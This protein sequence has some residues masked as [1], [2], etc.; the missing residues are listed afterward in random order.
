MW[1][2]V[3]DIVKISLPPECPIVLN[4]SNVD[5]L[6][7]FAATHTFKMQRQNVWVLRMFV[8]WT[9]SAFRWHTHPPNVRI[10]IMLLMWGGGAMSLI[11]CHYLWSK[12]TESTCSLLILNVLYEHFLHI[13]VRVSL[14]RYHTSVLQTVLFVYQQQQHK[15]LVWWVV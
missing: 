5:W 12:I 3:S 9:V 13:R 8:M 14:A 4:V 10:L 1:T 15:E 6:N 11:L 2:A 7:F